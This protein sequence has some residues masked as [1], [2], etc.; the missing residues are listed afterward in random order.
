MR[1]ALV[2]LLGLAVAG[3]ASA[4][5]SPDDEIAR[6]HFDAG[7]QAYDQ[8]DYVVALKELEAAR[9]VRALPALDYDIA[10]CLDRMERPAEAIDAYERYLANS[11]K[12][13]KH[14]RPAS[15]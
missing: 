15:I 13:A 5:E 1:I 10:R 3:V 11:G 12:Q 6:R 2:V 14:A 9:T 8:H 4:Q 7:P